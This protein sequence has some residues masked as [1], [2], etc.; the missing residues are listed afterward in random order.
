M[1]IPE[2]SRKMVNYLQEQIYAGH[3]AT[4]S[5]LPTIRELQKQFDL[6]YTSAKRGI[7]Y[8]CKIGLVES[9]PRSGVYVLER[10][11]QKSNSSN[12]RIA[13]F[14]TGGELRRVN[15]IYSSVFVGIQRF[16]EQHEYSL[17][18][19]YL[20]SEEV[21]SKRIIEL[22]AGANGVIFLGEYDSYLNSLSIPVPC[23]GVCMHDSFNGTLSIVDLDPF[24]CATASVNYFQSKEIKEVIIT[25]DKLFSD[26]YKNREQIFAQLW[27]KNGGNISYEYLSDKQPVKPNEA[28]F[29][30]TTSLFQKYSSY[31]LSQTGKQ[32]FELAEVLSVDGKNLINP[33]FHNTSVIA[34]DW[35]LVGI[36]AMEECLRRVNNPGSIPHRIYL[37]GHLVKQ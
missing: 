15:G 13:L 32:L 25:T 5:K 22:S 4:G 36:A 34:L 17:S 6:S 12:I 23:V 11:M 10:P 35:S 30:A 7:D 29:F 28:Y 19:H 1:N 26:S 37:R 27:E 8:L 33:D 24:H 20:P 21:N 16:A 31:V 18:V 3:F 2:I 9:R 14:T